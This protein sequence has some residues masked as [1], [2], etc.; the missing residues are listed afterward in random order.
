MVPHVRRLVH[1]AVK[2]EQLH[3]DPGAV[4]RD[5]VLV[6]WFNEG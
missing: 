2:A 4:S 6:S 5:N 3:S 1:M